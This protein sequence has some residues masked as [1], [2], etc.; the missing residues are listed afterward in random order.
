M[1]ALVGAHL[2]GVRRQ[3]VG[4]VGARGAGC[5]GDGAQ[6]HVEFFNQGV[7]VAQAIDFLGPGAPP[8]W[9]T[10][11]GAARGERIGITRIVAC[12]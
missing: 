10:R 11:G 1:A 6:C 4:R 12:L 9:G 5:P 3:L 2:F 7:H 8:W